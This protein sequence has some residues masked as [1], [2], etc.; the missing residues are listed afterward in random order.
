V[1]IRTFSELL[2]ERFD[3]DEFRARFS[4]LVGQDVRR[5][6]E[7]VTRLQTL[8][9]APEAHT[10]QVDM[11]ALLDDLLEQHRDE[12]QARRLLVLKELD[13]ENP[14]AIADAVQ[15]RDALS[16]LL[17]KALSLLP[18]QGD[19]YVASRHHGAGRRGSPMLRVL[20]RYSHRL[21]PATMGDAQGAV[22]EGMMLDEKSLEVVVAQKVVNAH[23][24]SLT[25]D[26][27][28]GQETVII[29]DLPAPA[30]QPEQAPHT[31]AGM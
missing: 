28:D 11:G 21:V 1:S 24:G 7:L 3:D 12:I 17:S 14:L 31:S 30:H 20:L 8:T 13:R 18:E 27:S 4:E 2:P 6:D 15:L 29:I 26:S 22:A 5:I 25:V 10:E 9:E 19:I 16:G 23:G